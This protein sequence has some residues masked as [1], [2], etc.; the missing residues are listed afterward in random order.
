M[1]P[2][3][4][5]GFQYNSPI[6]RRTVPEPTPEKP[7]TK[8]RKPRTRKNAKKVE[9]Q[10]NGN[11][12][13][14]L[15]AAAIGPE[16][17][18][19]P[20]SI[21]QPTPELVQEPAQEHGQEHGQEP[22]HELVP[23]PVPEPVPEQISEPAQS[24]PP[25][26]KESTK[27]KKNQS[28]KIQVAQEETGKKSRTLQQNHRSTQTQ[29]ES[30]D[31]LLSKLYKYKESPAAYSAS[32]QK[33]I[34]SNYSLSLHKQKRK[35]F[36]R[37]PFIVYDPYDAIQADLVFYAASEFYTQNS[38]YKYILYVIDMFSKVAYAEPLKT[39]NA[40]EVAAAL[41]KIISSMP[42]TPRRLMVDAGTE[43]S[44]TSNAIYNT[45]VRKYKMVI[46]V[47]TDS[48]T[49]AAVVERFNRTLRERLAYY[50]TEHKTKRWLDYLPEFIDQY[51]STV[52]SSIGMAPRMVSFENREEVFNKLY[53]NKD[54][55][56]KCKLKVGWRV[57]I[58]RKKGIFEK[59]Y[60]PNWSEEIY[61]ISNVQQ[62]KISE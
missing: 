23:E 49:K 19:T 5:P 48:Q 1:K 54:I 36:R 61:I 20:E 12:T 59:G 60:A 6:I 45:I 15:N 44:G 33:Y 18:S 37:R 11:P 14:E 51:N 4:F 2:K 35:K 57:R 39:K 52:H 46:Y 9:D 27:K 56:T 26:P 16:T 30:L 50:M 41:D 42:I 8:P 3:R 32:V 55:K 38:Y 17:V 53:P 58:P 28:S 40:T 7:K 10:L 31:N 24:P 25:N 47:L 43:F 62:V 34:D 21:E 22:V 13:V 29:V